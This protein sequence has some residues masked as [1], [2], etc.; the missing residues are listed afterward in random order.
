MDDFGVPRAK[1]SSLVHNSILSGVVMNAIRKLATAA[2][3]LLTPGVVFASEPARVTISSGVGGI[4]ILA[5]FS[6]AGMRAQ[7]SASSGWRV[8]S[9]IF[10]FPGTLVTFLAVQEGSEVAL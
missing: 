5:N 10:G 3:A 7:N 2:G 4:W 1:L 6:Y 8:V 9:F